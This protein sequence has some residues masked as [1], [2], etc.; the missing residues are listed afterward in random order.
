M[1]AGGDRMP[2]ACRLR[3]LSCKKHFW[4]TTKSGG[5][6]GTAHSQVESVLGS[7]VDMHSGLRAEP[8]RLNILDSEK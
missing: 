5:K 7:D 6:L 8:P 4:H 1:T 2:A 3:P